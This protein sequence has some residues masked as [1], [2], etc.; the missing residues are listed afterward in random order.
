METFQDQ[1]RPMPCPQNR[2]LLSSCLPLQMSASVCV[3]VRERSVQGSPYLSVICNTYMQREE[4]EKKSSLWHQRYILHHE[5]WCL[6]CLFYRTYCESSPTNQKQIFPHLLCFLS[7][8]IV[9][10]SLSFGAVGHIVLCLLF[11]LMERGKVSLWDVFSV[12]EEY[13]GLEVYCL[14]GGRLLLLPCSLFFGLGLGTISA[15]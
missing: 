8:W 6:F 9:L 7:L 2:V 1:I 10:A 5:R 14:I 11:N 13:D 3:W 15:H 12:D 4:G